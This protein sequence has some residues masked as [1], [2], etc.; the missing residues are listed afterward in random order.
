MFNEKQ[1]EAINSLEGRIKVIASAGS[2]KTAVITERY[3]K[4]IENGISPDNI[5]CVT[6][7]NKAANEMKNRIN[8][9]LD[10]QYNLD[11]IRTFHGFC[12]KILKENSHE[13]GWAKNFLVWDSDDQTS[14]IKRIY[15]EC[16]IDYDEVSYKTAK[17]IISEIKINEELLLLNIFKMDNT[18]KDRYEKLQKDYKS[19]IIY[20]DKNILKHLI[21]FGYLYYQQKNN[22][23]DFNDMIILTCTLFRDKKEILKYWQEKLKYIMVDEFQD[24]SQRQYELVEMLSKKHNNLF[25]VGD[26]DQTIYSWRGAKPE[27]LVNFEGKTIIMNQNYRSTP[28]ILDA[29]NTIIAKNTMRI[30]KDLFTE[31]EHGKKVLCKHL[32]NNKHE[33]K[34]VTQLIKEA[35]KKYEPKDIAILYRMHYLS[36]SIEEQLIKEKIPYIIHSGVNFYERKEIKDVLC[37]LRLIQNPNDDVAFERVINVP[38]RGIGYKTIDQLKEYAKLHNYSLYEAA[39]KSNN[40]KVQDFILLL[41]NLSMKKKQSVYDLTKYILD[42]TGYNKLLEE[43]LEPERIENIKEL[44]QSIK[45][46]KSLEDYLQEITLL[47][48]TDK[49]SVNKVTLMTIHSSKGLEF[50]IVFVIGMSEKQF[51]CA[52]SYESKELEE[53]ERRLAYVAFTRAKKALILTDNSGLDFDGDMKE[54]SRYIEE[55]KNLQNPCCDENI[56]Y[57]PKMY[58]DEE[59][60]ITDST[61]YNP[62]YDIGACLVSKVI[63]N[64]RDKYSQS[65]KFYGQYFDSD[66]NYYDWDDDTYLEG[67]ISAEDIFD[68]SDFY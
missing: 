2:G 23:I 30:E 32:N 60:T 12:L 24:V 11:L 53:E 28:E 49:Q 68:E 1:L 67:S 26:P 33:A 31:N 25:V 46:V 37:Y 40:T 38:R 19:G 9:K 10:K 56:K 58:K 52:H 21:Y 44:L 3:I 61:F 57:R 50:P 20:T 35:L 5:L 18:L 64:T 42:K 65:G 51:P 14:I 8:N 39:T 66:G 45:D 47:T 13:F 63:R 29:A 54:T 17:D 6:F 62:T 15:K 36:R 55:V 22:A 16:N 59:E 7:T 41:G 43:S 48:N 27:L 34:Y 4:L